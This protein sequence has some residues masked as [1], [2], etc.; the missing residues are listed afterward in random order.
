MVKLI[1]AQH[2][3]HLYEQIALIKDSIMIKS[4]FTIWSDAL[5]QL[6][7]TDIIVDRLCIIAG[8]FILIRG[9]N[10]VSI[11]GGHIIPVSGAHSDGEIGAVR[12]AMGG[13]DYPV[14]PDEGTAA[15]I[16]VVNVDG[17]LPWE[18][19]AACQCST[20]NLLYNHGCAHC[21]SIL[22]WGEK[23]FKLFLFF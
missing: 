16:G 11:G 13:G 23:N 4:E 1:H 5:R 17:H 18:L 9:E 7:Q 20:H 8:V 22:V 21:A 12:G 10:S 3:F 19:A 2:E 15:K 14:V 6:Q